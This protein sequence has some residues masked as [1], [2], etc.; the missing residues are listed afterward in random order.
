MLTVLSGLAAFEREMIRVRT[1]D[2]RARAVARGRQTGR[3]PA[4]TPHQR[5]EAARAL[6]AG[7]TQADLARQFDVS[8]S[9]ISRL[10]DK[11]AP[12]AAKP[13]LDPETER[14]ARAFMKR[15]EGKYSVVEAI[16]YGS[17]ARRTHN[18]ESDADIAV[19]L[20]GK[21]GNLDAAGS[22]MAGI[23]FDVMQ[24]TGVLIHALP[25][26]PGNFKRPETFRNPALIHN[27]KRDGLRL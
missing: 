17:R 20:S 16:L 9:T 21:P 7:T 2:G 24:D 26:S 14:A 18:S 3:P 25:L 10:A 1:C 22:E 5:Q 11:G 6:A 12:K 27:I 15:L 13:A 23:A 4:L 8:Q 19:V